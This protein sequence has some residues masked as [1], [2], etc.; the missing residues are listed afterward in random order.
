MH[1]GTFTTKYAHPE[2]AF[3]I[4]SPALSHRY[5]H[6]QISHSQYAHSCAFMKYAHTGITFTICTPMLSHKDMHTQILNSRWHTEICTQLGTPRYR[7]R[8]HTEIWQI[9]HSKYALLCVHTDICTPRYHHSCAFNRRYAPPDMGFTSYE[10]QDVTLQYTLLSLVHISL[11]K[12]RSAYCECDIWMCISLCGIGNLG[13]HIPV[14]NR[15]S[16]FCECDI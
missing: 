5:M 10:H 1:P 7:L 9:S 3:T 15:S 2:M 8:F 12:H 13:V 11:W 16:A 6:T 14:W 4:C